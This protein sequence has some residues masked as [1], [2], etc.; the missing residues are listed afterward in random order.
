VKSSKTFESLRRD[1]S[2]KLVLDSSEN[3]ELEKL[4]S[5]IQE[6]REDVRLE[7]EAHLKTM[8]QLEQA[9]RD[10]EKRDNREPIGYLSKATKAFSEN[11]YRDDDIAVYDK[12]NPFLFMGAFGSVDEV[13]KSKERGGKTGALPRTS[14]K[15]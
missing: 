10:I 13:K 4:K 2:G 1:P 7:K 12:F 15:W 8:E 9:K 6:L 3:I 5:E 14:N 11:K